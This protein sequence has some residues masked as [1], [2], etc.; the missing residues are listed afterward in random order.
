MTTE[1]KQGVDFSRLEVLARLADTEIEAR[2]LVDKWLLITYDIPKS[3]AGDRARREFLNQ[4]R[5]IGAT[6]HTDSVY[7][8]PWTKHAEVLALQLARAG[9][10]CVWTS[11]TTDEVKAAEITKNYD[12]GLQP[13]LDEISERVDKIAY[14]ISK[15]RMKR[16]YKMLDKTERMLD[17]M[18]QAIIRRGSAQLYVLLTLIKER[19][20]GVA[21][22]TWVA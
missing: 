17:N 18:E 16:A 11:Q 5:M 21:R 13:Q 7:L 8:M 15:E 10:V 20:Q 4:A 3:E 12:K 1:Q 14:N 6:R 2:E 22:A 9:E 19:F